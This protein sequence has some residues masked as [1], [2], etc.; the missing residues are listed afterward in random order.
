MLLF[1]G[2][3]LEKNFGEY[4][5]FRNI[6]FEITR[7]ERVGIVGPNG[8]GKTTL[9]KVIA[10]EESPS[11][12]LLRFFSPVSISVLNQYCPFPSALQV[13]QAV[14]NAAPSGS[15]VST[16]EILKKFGFANLGDRK[17]GDLSGGEK[18]RLQLACIWREPADLLLLDEPTNH[19]DLVQLDWL[20]GFIR[21]YPGTI[22]LVS[23]DRYFLDRT[24]SRVLELS[25][26]GMASFPGNY[27]NYQR[28]K[29]E[30]RARDERLFAEQAR[31][32]VKLEKAITEQVQWSAKAHRESAEKAR[33]MGR[34]KGGK[35]YLRAK[36]KKIDR[37]VNNTVKRLERLRREKITKP[38]TMETID[39]SF[40]DAGRRGRQS[41]I[42]GWGLTK[43]Y[44][45]RELFD[46]VSLTL[47]PGEKIGLIGRNGSGKTT[48]LK[49]LL[50]LEQPDSGNVWSSPALQAGYLDQEAQSLDLEK[51]VLTEL[52]D[53][54]SDP[55]RARKLLAG[56]LLQGD[57]VYK[58]CA[59]LSMG[60]RVRV[61]LA[62][63]LLGSYDLLM[64]DEPTN[65]LDLESRERLEEALNDF[66]GALII[67]S[68]DRYL[69][70]R[71]CNKIWSLENRRLRIFPGKYSEAVASGSR[72][73]QTTDR[74]AE[75]L[76]LGFK[77]A[78]ITGRLSLID[79][80]RNPEEYGIL[81]AEYFLLVEKY[82]TLTRNSKGK[83]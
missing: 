77:M 51:T 59:S 15:P 50:G 46:S 3:K 52:V 19:L 34:K 22:I 14:Q 45:G 70:E 81:E 21:E 27:T 75:K 30:Q 76:R 53:V 25:P 18:T 28:I 4:E 29:A 64:L 61:E 65:Y 36:A 6:S 71:V 40:R 54:C 48:L 24:V 13:E 56:L 78:D 83:G 58:Q 73:E 80:G 55:G 2:E 43:S 44:D 60:E 1:S 68:H 74:E 9:L 39:L 5:V 20:E 31:Q 63:L 7:L 49:I 17:I 66:S 41:L 38:A 47:Q 11:A 62:K 82:Q 35:E 33:A 12:G 42:T 57:T 72:P 8:V 37:R 23:H 67:V 79:R 16:E 69:L 26:T 32:A 10:G